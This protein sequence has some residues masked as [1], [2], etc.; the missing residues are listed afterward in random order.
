LAQFDAVGDE[1]RL[2]CLPRYMDPDHAVESP[3]GTFIVSYRHTELMQWQFSEVNT[4]GQVLR[5]FSGTRPTLGNTPHIAVDSQGN[6]FAVS[7]DRDRRRILQ[8]DRQLAVC[9]IIIDEH[10]LN[11]RQPR[12]LCFVEQSGQLLV[13]MGYSVAVFDMLHRYR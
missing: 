6:I 9:C 2:A 12:R 13:G 5:Q 1:L 3:T 11:S 8:L 7:R 4:E 10:Q